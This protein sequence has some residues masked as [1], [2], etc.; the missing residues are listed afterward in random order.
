MECFQS[1]FAVAGEEFLEF[2]VRL[3]GARDDFANG[4]VGSFKSRSL[5]GIGA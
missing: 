3:S 2:E 4:R 5:T 1:G